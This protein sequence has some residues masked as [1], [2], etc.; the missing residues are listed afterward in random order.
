M[1][2]S[3]SHDVLLPVGTYRI[4]P[5]HSS[6]SF[7]TRHF[8]GLGRVRGTASVAGGEI[9]IADPSERSSVTAQVAADSITTGNGM[10]DL[11]VRSRMFLHAR[12]H[13]VLTFESTA[14]IPTRDGWVIRGLLTAKGGTAPVELT[15]L[16]VRTDEQRLVIEAEGRVDRYAHGVTLMKGM[17]A[18]HL[19]LHIT[20][21]AVPA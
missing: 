8:F 3:P 7:T 5:S 13:P 1:S 19:D 12:V 16:S 11:Q 9:H 6:V 18:R 21:V 20:V 4:T 17:A 15:V 10:R 2:A 14:T